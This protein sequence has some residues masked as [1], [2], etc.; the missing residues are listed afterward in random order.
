[1]LATCTPPG[2]RRFTFAIIRMPAFPA[3]IP[4]G[5]FLPGNKFKANFFCLKIL[6][7]DVSEIQ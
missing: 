1:M 7:V 5:P 3:D 4:A 2:I 6:N